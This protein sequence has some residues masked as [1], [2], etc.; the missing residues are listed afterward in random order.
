MRDIGDTM[1]VSTRRILLIE[2]VP[3][4]TAHHGQPLTRFDEV[5]VHGGEKLDK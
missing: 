3:S 2:I 5:H 1:R 4:I